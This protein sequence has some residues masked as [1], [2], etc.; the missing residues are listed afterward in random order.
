MDNSETTNHT[1]SNNESRSSRRERKRRSKKSLKPIDTQSLSSNEDAT[2]R[3][4]TPRVYRH[5]H[6]D[7]DSRV[8]DV[9]SDHDHDQ[10]QTDSEDDNS[11]NYNSSDYDTDSTGSSTSYVQIDENPMYQIMSTFLENNSLENRV[12]VTE[13]ILELKSSVDRVADMLERLVATSVNNNAT[14]L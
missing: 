13:A 7:A 8:K 11:S 9:E 4:P 2:E 1:H 6:R 3:T 14:V 12:N 10:D 5:S